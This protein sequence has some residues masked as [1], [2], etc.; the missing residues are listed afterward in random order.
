[1]KKK[2]ACKSLTEEA[3]KETPGLQ[4]IDYSK[5]W[6][7]KPLTPE[8]VEEVMKERDYVPEIKKLEEYDDLYYLKMLDVSAIVNSKFIEEFEKEVKECIQKMKI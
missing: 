5:A 3:V 6:K 2:L 8:M 4:P 7:Y 1:M